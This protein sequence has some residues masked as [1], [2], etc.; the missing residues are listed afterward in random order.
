MEARKI[1]ERVAKQKEKGT[2]KGYALL[3]TGYGPSGL[4]HIGTFGEVFRTT[5]VLNA[6]K[7]LA[8]DLPA[9]IVCFSDDMDGLRK[10]PTNVPNQELLQ[11]HLHKSL[12][13]VPDPFEKFE[14]FGAHNNAML[15]QFLDDFGFEYEFKSST[16]V[17]KSGAFDKALLTLLE[18]HEDICNI[19]KPTLGEERRKTYSP[20][21]PVCPETGHVLQVPVIATDVKKGTI[22]Y[23]RE[24]GQEITT[25][26]TGGQVKIQWKADW[27]LRWFAL[28]VDYEMSGKDLIDSVNIGGRICRALGGEPPINLMYEHF[29]DENGAKIS[30][31]KGNGLTIEEW[32]SYADKDSLAFFM[33]PNPQR[34]KKL[35][36]GVI[37]KMVDDYDAQVAKLVSQSPEEQAENPAWHIN[38]GKTDIEPLPFSFNMLLN[39]TSVAATPDEATVWGFIQNY[40]PEVTPEN[41]PRLAALVRGA[42]KYYAD[43]IASTKSYRIPTAEEV[44]AFNDVMALLETLTDDEEAE[45]IQTE[46]Y[47]IGKKYFEKK[48]LRN[49]FALLYECLFGFSQGPRLGSFVK[50]YGTEATKGLVESAIERAEK[51]A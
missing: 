48:E 41:A 44:P 20:F 31:S 37:P 6:L 51:A 29:V 8:P 14:S 49:W 45:D 24:D 1:I 47:T 15:N 5:M 38:S 32:L 28:G 16:E 34:T 46:F 25:G 9:K 30:K 4:P 2:F 10:V 27:A 39:L 22:T 11:K 36:L 26:V 17:F 42:L 21:L 12:S 3:E 13:A 50:I 19:V 18:K 35:F 7:A 23:K 43:T 33:F 40:R